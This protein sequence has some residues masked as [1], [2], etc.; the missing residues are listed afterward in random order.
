MLQSDASIVFSPLQNARIGADEEIDDAKGKSLVE[1][2]EE[3]QEKEAKARATI[4]EMVSR[5]ERN[6][7]PT[8]DYKPI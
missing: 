4:L 6:F 2:E 8:I 7:R 1:I 5:N 3:I